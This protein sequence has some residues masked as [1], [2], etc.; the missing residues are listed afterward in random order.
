MGRHRHASP[1][2]QQADAYPEAGKRRRTTERTVQGRHR[3]APNPPGSVPG[4]YPTLVGALAI[5]AM[6]G[7][8]ALEVA[9]QAGSISSTV[10]W[11]PTALGT[12]IAF[13]V[14]WCSIAWLLRLV[15]HHPISVFV[16]YRLC[17]A[18]VVISLLAT[19]TIGAH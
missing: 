7:A 14:G 2:K 3:A 4:S 13:A 6:V 5:P 9:S 15:A 12:L 1:S 17:A 11:V 16:P 8:G 10:G 18:G 19:G